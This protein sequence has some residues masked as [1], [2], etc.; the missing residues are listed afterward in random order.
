MRSRQDLLWSSPVFPLFRTNI[1]RTRA[2]FCL[3]DRNV[4]LE[5]REKRIARPL[6]L[7]SNVSLILSEFTGGPLTMEQRTNPANFKQLSKLSATT[8]YFVL[9][10][11]QK[12]AFWLTIASFTLFVS[13][14]FDLVLSIS[15]FSP[16]FLLFIIRSFPL[17]LRVFVRHNRVERFNSYLRTM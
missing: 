4:R 14:L 17:Q 8:N 12:A 3:L 11:E 5:R 15:S 1:S 13:F 10:D 6:S 2:N 7:A 16:L 9:N